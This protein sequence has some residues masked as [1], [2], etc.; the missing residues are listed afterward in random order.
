MVKVTQLIT[1]S[2]VIMTRIKTD[3]SF[4]WQKVT[5]TGQN[6]ISYQKDQQHHWSSNFWQGTVIRKLHQPVF[7]VSI[8]HNM[9][10]LE[11]AT[12]SL[13][14]WIWIQ[15]LTTPDNMHSNNDTTINNRAFLSPLITLVYFNYYLS[16]MS[17]VC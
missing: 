5:S 9:R 1:F 8:I 6:I 3:L 4:Q 7:A 12:N 15:N 10:Q 11:R 17:T 2:S 13:K 14:Q 16:S